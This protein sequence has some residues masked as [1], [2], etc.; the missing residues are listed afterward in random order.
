MAHRLN[1]LAGMTAVLGL[2]LVSSVGECLARSQP[3]LALE[4]AYA[5]VRARKMFN[6]SPS[7]RI[8][9]VRSPAGFGLWASTNHR[10]SSSILPVPCFLYISSPVILPSASASQ[11]PSR[12]CSNNLDLINLCYVTARMENEYG[13]QL[14]NSHLTV[15]DTPT[16][17]KWTAFSQ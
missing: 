10:L 9:P 15:R 14:E 6:S 13:E 3:Q 17:E 11:A 16:W 12:L 5:I 1:W 2:S 4:V 8:K 7:V